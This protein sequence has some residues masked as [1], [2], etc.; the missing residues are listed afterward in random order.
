MIS[1]RTA[2]L[3][4]L[5]A[6]A[7]R[8]RATGFPGYAFVANRGENSVA[9]IDLTNFTVARRIRLQAAPGQVLAN[10]ARHAIYVAAP[11]RG[12]IYEF[13]SAVLALKRQVAIAGVLVDARFSAGDESMW[14]L[15]RAP[16][17]LVQ[18]ALDRFSIERRI[19]LP[20]APDSFDLDRTG[21]RAVVSL[22][23]MHSIALVDLAKPAVERVTEAGGDPRTVLFRLDGL[24]IMVA[25]RSERMITIADAKDAG[26]VVRLRLPVAPEHLCV[27]ADGGQVF[28][29]G[30]GMDA[31]AVVYPYRTEV[32]ETV[33]AG[34]SP[35]AM[36]I[37][38]QPELLF[39]ANPESGD[40]TV[41][42]VE[43]L[44]VVA[45]VQVGQDPCYI[46]FTPDSQY[47]LVVDRRSGDLAVIR[48]PAIRQ[49]R[50]KTAALFTMVPVGSEPV[51]VAV[52]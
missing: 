10:A 7:C 12:V 21:H 23:D 31:V 19:A 51:G 46:S 52:L 35:G 5:A 47:A 20:G 22:P 33:L 30:E 2:F 34:H 1:R 27:K 40:V 15:A 8:R 38:S 4:P 48:I 18:V 13:D 14:V 17:A 43:T 11:E 6:A 16:H 32:N 25:N 26:V 24:Q 36:A 44:N 45:A 49:S 29:S 41:L 42:D 39:V 28:V 3:L 9:A 50:S 37:S